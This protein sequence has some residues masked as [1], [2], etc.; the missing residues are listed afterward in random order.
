MNLA[1]PGVRVL[2]GGTTIHNSASFLAEIEKL[3]ATGSQAPQV[4]AHHHHQ[5]I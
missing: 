5:H 2:L 3:A 4:R 1:N